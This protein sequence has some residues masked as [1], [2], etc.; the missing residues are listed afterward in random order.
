MPIVVLM[1]AEYLIVVEKCI[2]CSELV[3]KRKIGVVHLLAVAELVG[4]SSCVL[5]A[6]ELA[7]RDGP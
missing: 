2:G 7:A 1:V 3:A 6:L 4:T 5:V